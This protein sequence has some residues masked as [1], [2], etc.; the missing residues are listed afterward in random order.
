M[1]LC[2]RTEDLLLVRTVLSCPE[3]E[4]RRVVSWTHGQHRSLGDDRET[5]LTDPKFRRRNIEAAHKVHDHRE[6][7][8]LDE[9]DRK[10]GHDTGNAD[11][12]RPVKGIV[13]LSGND[14]AAADGLHQLAELQPAEKE[15]REE[16]GSSAS[17]GTLG[18]ERLAVE[19]AP[20]DQADAHDAVH[21][22]S[23]VGIF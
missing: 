13:S 2:I 7:A 1:S 20:H 23:L 12:A 11:R 17:E 3:Q 16:Q 5:A 4:K 19:E 18:V 10:V 8:D 14:C 22:L 15:D 21:M 6:Y 9:K